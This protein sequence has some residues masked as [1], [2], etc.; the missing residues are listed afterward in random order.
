MRI[1]ARTEPTT[2]QPLRVTALPAAGLGVHQEVRGDR[3]ITADTVW[4]RVC[5][6]PYGLMMS[7]KTGGAAWTVGG[8]QLHHASLVLYF[9]ITTS[10]NNSFPS[11]LLNCLYVNMFFFF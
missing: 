5:P 8:E 1:S 2:S 10:S 3:A 6:I 9:I 11:V 7:N 4:P